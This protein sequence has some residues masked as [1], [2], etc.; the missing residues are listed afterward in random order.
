M[1][2]GDFLTLVQYAPPVKVILSDNSPFATVELE[3]SVSG[4]PSYGTTNEIPDVAAIVPG[5]CARVRVE[6]PQQLT[7]GR[8]GLSGTGTPLRRT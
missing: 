8:W 5:R 7:G 3:T 1:P 4:L 2:V 6:R